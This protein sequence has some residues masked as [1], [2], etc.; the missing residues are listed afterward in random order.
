MTSALPSIHY[1]EEDSFSTFQNPVNFELKLRINSP[2][3]SLRRD[4]LAYENETRGVFNVPQIDF[5]QN[6]L[7]IAVYSD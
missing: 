4:L 6:S 1:I 7:S 2:S 5:L 3:H